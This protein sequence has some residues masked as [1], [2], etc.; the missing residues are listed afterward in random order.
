MLNG[1][2]VTRFDDSAKRIREFRIAIMDEIPA[3]TEKSPFVHRAITSDL[4]YPMIV[5]MRCDQ[6]FLRDGFLDG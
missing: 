4:I 5:R 1:L 6:R 3:N 2:N